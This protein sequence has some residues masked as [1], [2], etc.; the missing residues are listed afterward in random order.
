[1]ELQFEGGK[2]AGLKLPFSMRKKEG[3]LMTHSG[4]YRPDWELS[5]EAPPLSESEFT[6]DGSTYSVS[7]LVPQNYPFR[8]QTVILD[9]NSSWSPWHME[10]VW[11]SV[12]DLEVFVFTPQKVQLTEDNYQKIY[13][14]L[15]KQQFSM[16]PFHRIGNPAAT[17]V[18]SRSSSRS[19][20]LQDLDKSAFASSLKSYMMNLNGKVRLYNIG[21]TLSPYLSTLR[22]FRLLE[23][24]EGD[25]EGLQTMIQNGHFR[26][27]NE[28]ANHI[29]LFGAGLMVERKTTG[30]Q[31][32][33]LAQAPD[34]LMRLFEYNDL[35]RQIGRKYFDREALEDQWVRQAERAYTVSPVSSLITL[36]TK[37]DYERFGIDENV[38]TLGNAAIPSDSSGS[39]PEPHEWVL[40]LLVGL[41]IFWQL[42]RRI[43]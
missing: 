37:Q 6:F 43:F 30:V 19:P 8:P 7:G 32:T 35:L 14:Q 11:Q 16:L 34:H 10:K 2:P 4:K 15:S 17:L 29:A 27:M 42:K 41:L 1:M 24:A 33:S 12:K 26:D 25:M 20:L 9:V 40:I 28:D 39:V 36:E 22:E 31:E 23:Y 18:I 5:F 13:H 21:S 3:D 38:N